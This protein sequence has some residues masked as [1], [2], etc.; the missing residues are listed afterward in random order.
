MNDHNSSL[1]NGTAVE[2][3]G[4]NGTLAQSWATFPGGSLRRYG[5]SSAIN[6]NKCMNIAGSKTANGTKINLANCTGNWNQT[7][8]YHSATHH[9]VNPHTGKCLDD[10]GGNLTNGTQLVIYACNTSSGEKWTNV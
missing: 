7:W 9:W 6:T 10:P 8:V 5:R 3:H 4:C 1:V 2:I